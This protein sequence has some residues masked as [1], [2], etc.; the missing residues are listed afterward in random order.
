MMQSNYHDMKKNIRIT[1]TTPCYNS[2]KTIEETIQSIISQNYDNFE[3]NI[4]NNLS[5]DGTMKIVDKYSDK[6]HAVYHERNCGI[7]D[8]FNR[9]IGHAE[10]ELLGNINSDDILLP[11]ALSTIAEEIEDDTDVI[12]G[13]GLRL[14]PDGTTAPYNCSPLETLYYK[15]ALVHPA[16]FVK[17]SAYEK[18]GV[19]DIKYRCC[20]DR[21]LLLR[22]YTGGAKFQYIQK[23]LIAYRMGGFSDKTYF[24]YTLPEKRE[25]SI[26]YGMPRWKANVLYWKDYMKFNLMFFYQ[27]HFANKYNKK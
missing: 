21:D 22:M 1:I 6:I 20:M 9:G 10:G 14:Y 5:E 23:P 26:K 19:F 27:K 4:V 24:K 16:V 17:K 15:M 18:Y 11:G 8:A 2:E 7:S 13:D 12:Y 25:I 3:Y